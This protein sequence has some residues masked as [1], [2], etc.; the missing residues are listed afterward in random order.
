MGGPKVMINAL[1]L[2]CRIVYWNFYV[3]I[4]SSLIIRKSIFFF[5]FLGVW[6]DGKTIDVDYIVAADDIYVILH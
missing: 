4:Y 3:P 6:T 2:S 5:E 1:A